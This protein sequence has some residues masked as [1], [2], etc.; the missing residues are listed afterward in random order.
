[1]R[2]LS[3]SP[4]GRNSGMPAP[5]VRREGKELELPADLAVVLSLASLET[6]EIRLELFLRRPG[7][8]VDAGKHRVLV[9]TPVSASDVLQLES[10]QSTCS[11]VR[12][13]AKSKN[14]PWR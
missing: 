9:A 11:D 10:T 12:A 4:L 2:C 1:M 3:I 14:S 5:H 7:R 13:A 8:A 6:P